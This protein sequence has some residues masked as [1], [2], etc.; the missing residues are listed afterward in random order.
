[1]AKIRLNND[2]GA[3]LG[4]WIEPWG[5]DHWMKPGQTFTVV[6]GHSGPP[7]SGEV[8]VD[9]VPFDVVVHDQGVSIYVNVVH[10]A[11]VYDESGTE[12]HCGHQRPLAVQHAWSEAAEAAADQAR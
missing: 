9:D 11:S 7:P 1:M 4:I 8:P 12:A 10:E 2:T 6:A 3:M 5:T